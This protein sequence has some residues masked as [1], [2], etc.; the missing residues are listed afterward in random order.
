MSNLASTQQNV[1]IAGIKDGIVI[2]KNGQYRLILSVGAINF[3]LKS[4]QEQ[5]SL[6]FQYQSF[7]NSLHFPIQIL[8]QS[9]KLD[10]TSYL[11]KVSVLADKQTNELL[12]L[13]TTDYI[14][15]VRQLIG[16]ANIM[17]KSF[18][19]VIGYQPLTS[20][21]GGFL[22]KIFG[23]K[24]EVTK[25]KISDSE[26]EHHTKELRQRAQTIASGLASMGL[27]AK[28]IS[29]QEAIE[30]FYKIYNPEVSSK[31]KLVETERLSSL[32]VASE[33]ERPKQDN[34]QA[35]EAVSIGGPSIDNTD[36]VQV[37]QKQQS[38]A[39]RHEEESTSDKETP[40]PKEVN[41]AAA[42]PA[43]L[44]PQAQTSSPKPPSANP[45]QPSNLPKIEKPTTP[46]QPNEAATPVADPDLNKN[47]GE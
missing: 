10:L 26:F 18:Y 45:D 7:L 4:E 34:E 15:F 32:F 36:Q 42:T 3:D 43:P 28:Q 20:G 11:K 35:S 14:D 1:P 17:K 2:L 44:T 40:K 23:K 6:V 9:K 29:T 12:K 30:T 5:N 8:I 16:V 41:V 37:A 46:P 24:T 19:V 13:Q 31:E 22:G 25:I 39:T 21:Q 47:F 27:H 38:V 33:S